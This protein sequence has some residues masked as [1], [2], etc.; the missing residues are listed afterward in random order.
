MIKEENWAIPVERIRAFFRQQPDVTETDDGFV[1][2]QCIIRL[3]PQS[4]QLLGK[5]QQHRTV[6]TLDGPEADTEEIYKR[7]FLRFLSA[8]G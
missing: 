8:G 2:R 4:D 6:I 5:W 3:A 1:F 7:F